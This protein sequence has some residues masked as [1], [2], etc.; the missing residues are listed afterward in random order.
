MPV[1]EESPV[2]STEEGPHT[3]V[4]RERVQPSGSEARSVAIALPLYDEEGNVGPVVEDLL[5]AFRK[6]GLELT[7]TLVD[8]GSRDGTR[9]EVEALENANIEVQGVYLDKNQGYGGG[10]LAGMNAAPPTAQ[11][12]GYMWGDGQ[13]AAEDVIRVYRRLVADN[14][15]ISKARRV[16]RKDGWRRTIVTRVYNTV[17]LW[18]FHITSNDT[19]GCPK[20][21]TREAWDALGPQ[22]VD[23]FLDPEIMIGVANR[24]M[25]LAEVDVISK[26]RDFGA[27]KVGATTVLEFAV[28]L[29][30][31]R[32]RGR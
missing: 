14:A 24:G 31:A 22:S 3:W 32:L 6:A 5:D 20:L 2:L 10:I 23:W 30:R 28:N 11:V 7:I 29:S 27:S 4:Q 26:A 16:Q 21:F 9:A 25:K 17:T 13:V 1:S 19:N 18:W 12:V 15:D 8:N